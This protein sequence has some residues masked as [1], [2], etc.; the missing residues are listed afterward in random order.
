[1][2][3]T[4]TGLFFAKKTTINRSN[5]PSKP[6]FLPLSRTDSLIFC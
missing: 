6:A 4:K 2:N 1:M 5:L 3:K